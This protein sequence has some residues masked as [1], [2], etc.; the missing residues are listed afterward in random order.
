[1]KEPH[2][3]GE[4]RTRAISALAK[5]LA[6][7]IQDVTLLNRAFIHTSYANETH[8]AEHLNNE[9][10]EFLGDAVLGFLVSEYLYRHSKTLREGDL[11]KMKARIVCQKVLAR[12]AR[13][14]GLGNYLLLGR[15]EEL[16]G[17]RYRDSILADCFEAVVGAVLLEC[18]IDTVREFVHQNLSQEMER[19]RRGK[20]HVTDYKSILQEVVQKELNLLPKYRVVRTVGPDHDPTFEVTVSAKETIL[21]MGQGKC[22]KEAEQL[23]AQNALENIPAALN[24]IRSNMNLEQPTQS[25]PPG[26]K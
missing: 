23:A 7:E 4:E 26:G 19:V 3:L 20:G 9:R 22:K 16:S 14:I 17:G 13:E 2:L 18:G 6:L 25:V 21:G 15:G 24:E 1:M 10:L 5:T 8:L 12:R 11:S